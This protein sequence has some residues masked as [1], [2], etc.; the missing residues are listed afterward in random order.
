MDEALHAFECDCKEC[1][2]K[3]KTIEG[4]YRESLQVWHNYYSKLVLENNEVEN[5]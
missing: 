2:D 3:W 1:L 4:D 5:G